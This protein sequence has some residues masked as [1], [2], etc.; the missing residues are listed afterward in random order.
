[1]DIEQ[2]GGYDDTV[3]S[4]FTF[5]PVPLFADTGIPMIFITLPGMLLLLLP[6]IVVE[7]MWTAKRRSI[8]IGRVLKASAAANTVS[9]LIGVSVAWTVLLL[10]EMVLAGTLFQIPQFWSWKSPIGRVATTILTAP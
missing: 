10:C 7:A 2:S 5:R 8:P 9:T 3:T 1:L 6:V 4:A